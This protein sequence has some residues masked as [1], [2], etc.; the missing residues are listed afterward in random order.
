MKSA[1]F[2][3][4]KQFYVFKTYKPEIALTDGLQDLII[5]NVRITNNFNKF[6]FDSILK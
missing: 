3:K 4:M 6:L 1:G 5:N 2:L